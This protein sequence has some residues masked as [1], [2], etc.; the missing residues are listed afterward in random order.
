MKLSKLLSTLLLGAACFVSASQAIASHIFVTDPSINGIALDSPGGFTNPTITALQGSNLDLLAGFYDHIGGGSHTNWQMHFRQT[1]GSLTLTDLFGTPNSSNNP[2]AP[3]YFL[4][5]EVLGTAGTWTGFLEPIN[6][7]SCPS[8]RYG[9]GTQG[10]GGCGSPSESIAF[11]L[12][13]VP[14]PGSLALLGLALAGIG[15]SRRKKA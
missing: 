15:F 2:G 9:N 10:G 11:S 14:E 4:F 5:S 1:G 8:Y 7:P 13:V 12:N 3:N 6:G